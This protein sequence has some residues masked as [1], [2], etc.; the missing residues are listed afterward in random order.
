MIQRNWGRSAVLLLLF[1][2]AAAAPPAGRG[3]TGRDSGRDPPP[4]P[5]P[6]S[7]YDST[8]KP[9]PRVDTLIV[10]ANVLDG[11]GNRYSGAVLVRDGKIAAV[12]PSASAQSAAVTIDANGRWLTPGI[13]DIHSHNGTYVAPLTANDAEYSDV[14]EIGSPNAAGNWVEHGMNAQDPSFRRALESGVT[15]LQILPGSIPLISGRSVVVKNVPAGDVTGMTVPGAVQGV[16]MS[17]GDNPRSHYGSKGQ[18]PNS[19]MGSIRMLREIFARSRAGRSEGKPPPGDNFD[20]QTVHAVLDGELPVHV[21]CYRADDM[22]GMLNLAREFGFRITAF[23]HAAEAYKIPAR[24][25]REGACAVV[26]S[27]WWGFKTEAADAIRANAAFVDA[28]GGCV[29]L[30]SDSPYMGQRLTLEAS[31]AMAAGRRE[32]VP[33]A[34]ER[35]IR[36]VT[37]N[38]ARMLGL[39][40]RTGSIAVGKDADL[41]LWSGDPFSVYSRAEQVFI[42]GAL[43]FDRADPRRQPRADFEIGRLPR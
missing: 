12:G 27:D 8:Y 17:C 2:L 43:V 7:A 33:I 16:K 11:A 28:A 19:R 42:D 32:G 24:L 6:T 26:W 31:K 15:T 13:I 1:T 34:P 39:G 22:I 36:W 40:D 4:P 5:V 21:H 25:N 38:P 10:N 29:A 9:L 30:H 41:V 23:H 14:T 37:S 18:S 20:A 35:A 3:D